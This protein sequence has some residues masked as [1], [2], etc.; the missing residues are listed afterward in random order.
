MKDRNFYLA[1]IKP[2]DR[3]EGFTMPL[4][5]GLGLAMIIVAASLI[6]RSQTDRLTTTSQRESNRAV[7]IAEAGVARSRSFLARYKFIATKN[8]NTWT[9]TLDSL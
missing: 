4:A 6:A 1:L 5:L 3:Q 8:L 2:G 9:S 7:S